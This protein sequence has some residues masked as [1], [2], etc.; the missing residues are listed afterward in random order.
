MWFKLSRPYSRSEILEAAGKALVKGKRKKAIAW[1]QKLLKTDPGDH[2][3]HGKIAPQLAETKQFSESWSSFK[4]SGE[5][6]LRMGFVDKA[7][8]MYIQATR[9]MPKEIEAWETVTRLQLDRRL[10]ADAVKTLINGHR[11]FRHRKHRQK[12]IRLLRKAKEIDPWHFEVTLNLARL[13]AKAGERKDALRL[14][15]ELAER[16]H[17]YKLRRICGAL[18]RISPTPASALRWLRATLFGT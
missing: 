9:Y 11:Y 8:S 7:L 14:L 15:N 16:E 2:V 6:Y 17:G 18:L 1:Y 10:R 13:L 12:A 4:A 3:V 5:G